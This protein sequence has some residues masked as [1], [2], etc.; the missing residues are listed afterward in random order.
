VPEQA[1][2]RQKKVVKGLRLKSGKISLPLALVPSPEGRG[3]PA[4][5]S[6]VSDVSDLSDVIFLIFHFTRLPYG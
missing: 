2:T 5:V 4:G 1:L 6:E 3:K